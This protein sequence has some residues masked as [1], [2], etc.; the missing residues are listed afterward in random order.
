MN[1]GATL[2][3]MVML[4]FCFPL[5]VRVAALLGMP[6]AVASAVLWTAVL[7]V[8]ATYLVRW[9]V[10]RHSAELE[11]LAQARAQVQTEPENPRSYFVGQE[12]LARIL[13]RLGRRREAA[14]II[15]RYSRLGGAKEAEIVAL[16]E[17]LGAAE[18]RRRRTLRV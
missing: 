15:D 14:E 8:L 1:Y 18:K 11:L 3:V 7:F 12:H 9:Q 5:A 17:A 16:K 13:L 2:A 10:G 6:A 4:A